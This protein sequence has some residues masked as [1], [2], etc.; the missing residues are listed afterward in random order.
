[1]VPGCLRA[2]GSAGRRRV[3]P[4]LGGE[5]RNSVGAEPPVCVHQ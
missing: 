5:E 1:L 4:A 2:A 3:L